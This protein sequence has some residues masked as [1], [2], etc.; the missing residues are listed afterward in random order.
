MIALSILGVAVRRRAALGFE[1]CHLMHAIR[2]D[3]LARLG[4]RADELN[5]LARS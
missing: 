2:A 5:E 3:L 1:G 4:R